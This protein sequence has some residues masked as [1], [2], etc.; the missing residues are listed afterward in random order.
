M[1]GRSENHNIS[2]IRRN[3]GSGDGRFDTQTPFKK[4]SRKED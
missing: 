2:R 3:L 4:L 1:P